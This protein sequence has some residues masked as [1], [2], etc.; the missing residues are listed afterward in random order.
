MDHLH[1]MLRTI[2]TEAKARDHR[3]VIREFLA[4]LDHL[5]RQA[6]RAPSRKPR[7]TK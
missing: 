4:H 2:R 5:Q 7:R 1:A 3:S 6:L